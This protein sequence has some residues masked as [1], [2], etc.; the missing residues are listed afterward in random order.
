[1]SDVGKLFGSGLCVLC[2]LAGAAPAA[3]QGQSPVAEKQ[4][5]DGDSTSRGA[6]PATKTA[7]PA[8]EVQPEVTP[9]DPERRQG[10]WK[11]FVN[12]QKQIWTSPSRIHFSDATW[13]VPLG[14]V[15]AG[16]FVTDR[17]FSRHL[18][19]DPNTIS[20]YKTISN[21]GVASLIGAAS[22]MYLWSFHSHNDHWRE[23]GFLAGEAA[24]NSLVTVETFKYSLG[25][26]RPF[27]GDGSGKFFQG[28]TSFPSEHAA[29]AWA[30]AG[31]LAHEYPGP[32]AKLFAYGMASAVSLSRVKARQHFPSDVVVGSV[33]GRLVAQNIYSR[34]HEPEIG[35]GPW[36]SLSQ[37]FGGERSHSSA[38]LG[39]PYVPL[40]SWIYPALDRLAALG[41]IDSGF[42]G[43]RPWTRRE[44]MRQ[45]TEADEKL[46]DTQDENSEVQK[47]VEALQREFRPETEAPGDRADRGAFRLESLYTRT[48]HIS[49]RPVNDGYH[50]AQTQIN[51]FG[52]PYGEGWSSVSGFS[53]YATRG[54]WVAYVRGEWQ[55]TPSV[56]ALSLAARQTIQQVDFLPQLPPGTPQPSVSRFELLDAYV[57]MTI[58]NWQVSFGKQS[59]WWGPGDGGPMMFSNNAEP[60]NMFRVNR[61]A[62]LKLPSILGW[63]GQMRTEFFLG[64]LSGYEFVLSPSGFTGQFGQALAQQ[65]FLHGQKVSFKP[66][67]NFEFGFFRTTVYG[68]AGYP[69]TS[70]T[71]LRSLLSTGNELAGTANKPGDRRSGLD[72]SYRLPRM[73]KWLTFY[74]DG[75]TDDEFSPIA[76]FDR[77]AW[78]AGLYLA[79][80]PRLQKLDLR[81]EGVY[82]DNPLGGALGHGFYYFNGTWRSGYRNDGNLI[83]SWIGRQGQGAQAW[84]N[85]WFNAR[86]RLQVNFRHEK[87]SQEFIP[88]GGTLS[89]FGITS[90]IQ[91]RVDVALSMRVQYERWFIPVIRPTPSENLTT[92]LQVVF[93]P[94]GW[95]R[96][97]GDGVSRSSPGEGNP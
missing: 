28:G 77:S 21:A 18:S 53:S 37:I 6:K 64:Q 58:S 97:R 50:F 51:D 67:R 7:S 17:E 57:G 15:T 16:L 56:T 42:A 4:G 22:G 43:M 48:E 9:G 33:I 31:V 38:N 75:F 10:I 93:S 41:F 94:K 13:L 39:S 79:Q 81:V 45:L 3:A 8:K 62:P 35:G 29:A 52:R 92:S 19:Q 91:V 12:D 61:V 20:H 11:D 69:L 23:T 90:D 1:M 96:K 55:T 26:A 27:Q 5:E 49:G 82:T 30:V 47:L 14:G 87:V 83:G 59:L 66:T 2:M 86:N 68:G 88:G 44:C 73:R 40:D 34:R 80:F 60:I 72:F 32:L 71:L 25:R 63:L 95:H 84:S 85:Y 24:L 36:E 76:Y 65:P 54:S 70:R 78:H 74:G 89:D 46:A